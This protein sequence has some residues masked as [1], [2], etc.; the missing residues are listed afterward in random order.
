VDVTPQPTRKSREAP[1][2][3]DL[4]GSRAGKHRSIG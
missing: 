3:P 1:I 4:I 2:L